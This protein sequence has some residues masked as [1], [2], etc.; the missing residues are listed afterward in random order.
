MDYCASLTKEAQQPKPVIQ[1]DQAIFTSIRSP[2]GEGYRI[3][4]LSPGIRPEEKV[5]ITR[6]SPSHNSLCNTSADAV[7]LLGYALSS[8]RFCVAYARTAGAEHTARGGQRI[9]THMVLLEPDT[10]RCFDCNPLHVRDALIEAIG[11]TPLL[12][13]PL[14]LETLPIVPKPTNDSPL[15]P[16]RS[17]TDQ[18]SRLERIHD[19]AEAMLTS[20]RA[21]VIGPESP[22]RMF[23]AFLAAVPVSIRQSLSFSV[24]IKFAPTRDIQLTWVDRDNPELRRIGQGEAFQW[25]DTH[26]DKP[27]LVSPFDGWLSL[28]NRWLTQGR[29]NDLH[30]LSGKLDMPPCPET[31]HKIATICDD[32]DR[33]ADAGLADL[34]RLVD[35][36]TGIHTENAVETQLVKRLISAAVRR[37]ACLKQDET[38]TCPV[39]T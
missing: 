5:E 21:I 17:R 25:I 20:R 39:S 28:V 22:W 15:F 18:E 10:Y 38:S 12:K 36:Y 33:V 13:P 27:A 26:A 37:A 31:L 7:G 11:P 23:D 32:L 34:E 9:H 3:V 1:A 24:G 2:T 35:R 29:L 6:R 16:L 14:C 30:R 4:A 8:Q 19:I